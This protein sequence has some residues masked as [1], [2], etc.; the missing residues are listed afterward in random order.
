MLFDK[1]DE[2]YQKLLIAQHDISEMIDHKLTRG[3][4]REDFLRQII[5]SQ[6]P[7]LSV[8]SGMITDARTQ[9]P[10]VDLIVTRHH[11]R[12]RQLWGYNIVDIEDVEMVI[13]VKSNATGTDLKKTNTD[14]WKIKALSLMK[15]PLCGIFCY[16][17]DLQH[18]TLMKR[19]GYS[20]N[21]EYLA[22]ESF[23]TALVQYP[24]IDF[25]ICIEAD[26]EY[27]ENDKE[28]FFIWNTDEDK[29]S[30]LYEKPTL[31]NIFAILSDLNRV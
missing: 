5:L 3:Q 16:R 12:F 19:F 30:Y 9:S 29:Y 13:E 23:D 28:V 21:S 20:W 24:N 14:F 31:K 8:I 7:G 17:M 26:E 6:F 18:Q 2:Y 25:L 27:P 11:C 1:F 10:Q 4:M 15:S 22:F